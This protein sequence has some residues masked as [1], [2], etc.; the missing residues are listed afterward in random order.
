VFSVR[1]GLD[2]A[3]VCPGAK[4]WYVDAAFDWRFYFN[5]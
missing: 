2:T 1:S 3:A 4:P 5:L